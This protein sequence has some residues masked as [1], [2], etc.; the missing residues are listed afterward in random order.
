MRNNV[1]E[2][3]WDVD[4]KYFWREEQREG[5]FG[6]DTSLLA[7]MNGQEKKA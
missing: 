4:T 1:E 5:E 6:S 2:L 7:W 3:E